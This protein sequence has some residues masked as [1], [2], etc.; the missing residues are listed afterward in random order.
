MCNIFVGKFYTFD[1]THTTTHNSRK[2]TQ[3]KSGVHIIITNRSVLVS[4]YICGVCVLFVC[5]MFFN[6]VAELVIGGN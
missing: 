4:A 5:H 3:Y 6:Y 1:H 2:T